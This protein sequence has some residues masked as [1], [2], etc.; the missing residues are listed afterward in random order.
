MNEDVGGG[1]GG[2]AEMFDFDLESEVKRRTMEETERQQHE[3]HLIN[4]EEARSR[5]EEARYRTE[6]A[7][8][9]VDEVKLRITNIEREKEQ[10]EELHALKCKQL[11]LEGG[12]TTGG[13]VATATGVS[14]G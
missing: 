9:R 3:L 7:R 1:G 11:A 8:L 5:A 10:G 6:E 14:P 2:G 12:T 4:L 13:V